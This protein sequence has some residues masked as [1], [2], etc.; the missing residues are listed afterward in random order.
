MA[1]VTPNAHHPGTPPN[2]NIA[3]GTILQASA[4]PSQ[5]LNDSSSVSSTHFIQTPPQGTATLASSP[6]A[7]SVPSPP[8]LGT[9]QALLDLATQNNHHMFR[10][11]TLP[12][13]MVT[14]AYSKLPEIMTAQIKPTYSGTV[15]GFFT[16]LFQ[17]RERQSICH[18][19]APATRLH[20]LDLLTN[21]TNVDLDKTLKLLASQWTPEF[22]ACIYEPGSL[23]C[24]AQ[25]L[26]QVLTTSIKVNIRREVSQRLQQ[27]PT[28]DGD[29]TAFWLCLT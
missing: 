11:A 26:Y 9:I 22:C 10:A 3:G 15:T 29:G 28:L 7:N 24:A 14:T 2:P 21:F 18:F 25:L 17:L 12:P 4:T 16:F 19:W 6:P 20:D 5:G 13:P 23:A 8:P 27:Y 1:L